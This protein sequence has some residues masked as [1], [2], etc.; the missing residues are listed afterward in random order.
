MKNLAVALLIMALSGCAVVSKKSDGEVFQAAINAVVTG[1]G[2]V[3]TKALG[4]NIP[5]GGMVTDQMVIGAGGGGLV[6]GLRDALTQLKKMPNSFLVIM[7]ENP[8]LD[9]AI[10][11]NAIKNLDL[12]GTHIVYSG[13]DSKQ[14][15]IAEV[16]KNAGAHYYFI[17]KR[18]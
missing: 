7:G 6:T 14:A 17:D 13:L 15:Q 10:I 1:S 12:S 18:K 11:S 8:S 3:N 2:N 16:I 4:F 9:Y 5:S